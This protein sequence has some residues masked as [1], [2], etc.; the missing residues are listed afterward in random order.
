MLKSNFHKDNKS[1]HGLYNQCKICRKEYCIKNS[2]KLIQRQKDFYLENRDSELERCK[3]YKI[4][5]REKIILYEKNK[6]KI[7]FNFKLAHNIRVRTRQA[8]KS[9]NV[10][11]LN[12]T[13]DLIG[14][15]QSFLRK[16]ILYQLLGNMT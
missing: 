15:S 6:R 2:I 5:N 16:W 7:D 12:K 13:F 4:L 9:Q 14:C 11:T 8:F 3:K 1:K 10:E